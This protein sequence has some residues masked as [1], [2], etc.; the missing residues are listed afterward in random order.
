MYEGHPESKERLRSLFVAADHWFLAFSVMLKSC[1]MPLYVGPWHV[2][3]AEIAVA[4]IPYKS[5]P[6]TVELFPVSK[7]EGAPCW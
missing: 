5:G 7:N 6:G 3:S 2:V 4:I 1:L